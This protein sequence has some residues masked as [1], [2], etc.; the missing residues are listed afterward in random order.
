MKNR[1]YT[2]LETGVFRQASQSISDRVYNR[3]GAFTFEDRFTISIKAPIFDALKGTF[4]E[5]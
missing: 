4:D 1:L 5:N 2:T 3:M